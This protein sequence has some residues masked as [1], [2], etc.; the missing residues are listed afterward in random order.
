MI[1]HPILMS[2]AAMDLIGAAAILFAAAGAFRIVL[3]W[4]PASPTRQQITLERRAEVMSIAARVGAWALLSATLVWILGVTNLLPDVVPGAMCGTGVFQ[5]TRGAGYR[6]LALRLA[7][8]LLLTWWAALDSVDR[9]CGDAPLTLTCARLLL[10][11]GP[12]MLLALSASIDAA[13]Q[14]ELRAPVDCCAVVYDRFDD[15]DAAR[16]T[17]GLSDEFW[18]SAFGLLTTAVALSGLDGCRRR[19]VPGAAAASAMAAS[20]CAWSAVA[21]VTLVRVL[22]AYHYGVLH[23]HCPWCLFLPEYAGAG[24]VLFG[25]LATAVAAGTRP[26]VLHLATRRI[27]GIQDELTR[28]YR[29]TAMLTL[30]C[31]V[32][33]SLVALGPALIWRIHHGVWIAG[34]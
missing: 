31:V 12:V 21:S 28:R 9:R 18:L 24:A 5:A 23:H 7:S 2:V 25:S 8:L 30:A 19:G 11:A 20:V 10:V 15:A 22:S 17:A 13:R 3:N 33:F 32:I 6:A 26:L 29:R 16:L 4:S 1:W 27:D 14:I 34:G